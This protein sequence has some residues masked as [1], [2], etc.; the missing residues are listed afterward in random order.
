MPATMWIVMSHGVSGG[1]A[2]GRNWP[3]AGVP[4][5]VPYG[6]GTDLLRGEHAVQVRPPEP[7]G[8]WALTPPAPPAPPPVTI[9]SEPAQTAAGPPQEKTL[10]QAAVPEPA[11]EPEPEPEQPESPKPG[12]PKQDWINYA[13]GQG[14]DEAAAEAMT[15]ADLMSRYGGRL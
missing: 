9:V 15:K 5:E 10:V 3:P 13:I 7:P 6:E 12:D 14:A 4:I 2:D 1:R 8:P 11:P